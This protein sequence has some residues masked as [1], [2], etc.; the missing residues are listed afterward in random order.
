LPNNVGAEGFSP[1]ILSHDYVVLNLAP[2]SLVGQAGL[3]LVGQALAAD[4]TPG[5]DGLPSA[6]GTRN[7]VG[8][9]VFFDGGDNFVRTYTIPSSDRRRSQTIV[10][11]TIQ[12]EHAMSEGFVLRFGRLRTDGRIVLVT[13]GEGNAIWQSKA[14]GFL[15]RREVA[16]VWTENANAIFTAARRGLR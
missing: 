12:G 8:G 2:P 3:A 6:T 7:D 9:L 1:G 16:R 11:Y 15:W 14:T 5:N 10:N 4:P 13:Y